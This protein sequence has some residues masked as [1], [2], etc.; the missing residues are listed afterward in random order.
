MP[1]PASPF[2]VLMVLDA[3][4]E[5]PGTPGFFNAWLFEVLGEITPQ[6][7]ATL[8][9][10]RMTAASPFY[11]IQRETY[12]GIEAFAVRIPYRYASFRET[13]AN[14]EM[15]R[16]FA[17][18]IKEAPFSTVHFFS[19]RNHSLGYPAIAHEAGLPAVLSISDGWLLHPFRYC[20]NHER[21]SLPPL[22]LAPFVASPLSFVIRTLEDRLTRRSPNW[23]F[24]E[25]GRYSMF[26]H[27]TDGTFVEEAVLAERARCVVEMFPYLRMVHFFSPILY[28]GTA[29]RDL[30][31][32][33][34]ISFIPQGIP[35]ARVVD[36]RPFDIDRSLSFG[37]IGDLIPEEGIFELIEA[38]NLLRERAIPSSLHIYGE[39]FG[40]AAIFRLL[41]ETARTSEV[42]FHGAIDYR[43]IGAILDTIDA[44]I[45]PARW[46]R[47]DSWL[48]L[49]AMARRKIVIAA[50]KTAA[51]ELV[52][53]MRRGAVLKEGDAAEIART[54]TDLE[55]DRKRVYYLMRVAES[56][57]FV[58]STANARDLIAL[59]QRVSARMKPKSDET[60]LSRR[61]GRKRTAR[62]RR[63]T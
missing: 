40:N 17:E 32:E 38:F 59:Y 24:E 41:K 42:F 44:L 5:E 30:I 29:Y 35:A 14:P 23:W 47:P 6:I 33:T 60:T 15:E 31:P 26:Y 10:P 56:G 48:A 50:A 19:L 8:L 21:N 51:G 53:K 43:R 16:V 28:Q 54:I 2:H 25:T 34:H 57:Q 4:P 20:G 37:F 39:T 3:P 63:K 13:F 36:S 52:K 12:R 58:S 7:R 11:R 1:S 18:V 49:Q 55:I 22:R 27:H 9:Y 61:L 46:P 62:S 45:I